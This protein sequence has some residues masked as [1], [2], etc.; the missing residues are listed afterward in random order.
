[1]TSHS[2]AR[3]VAQ[4]NR[5]ASPR[6]CLLTVARRDLGWARQSITGR[7]VRLI[8]RPAGSS[9]WMVALAENAGISGSDVVRGPCTLQV[10]QGQVRVRWHSSAT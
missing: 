6:I 9:S 4:V 2:A 3:P 7:S 8:G 5:R 1:M 10:L